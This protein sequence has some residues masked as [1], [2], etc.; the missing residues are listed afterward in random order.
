[1]PSTYKGKLIERDSLYA[2][3]KHKGPPKEKAN[4][5]KGSERGTLEALQMSWSSR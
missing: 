1:V 5:I 4:E 3:P 2:P